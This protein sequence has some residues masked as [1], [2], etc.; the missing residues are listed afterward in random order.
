MTSGLFGHYSVT[1]VPERNQHPTWKNHQE[2]QF[3]FDSKI[4]LLWMIK[5]TKQVSQSIYDDYL[6]LER[7]FS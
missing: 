2:F 7:G 3:L 4:L 1:A 5:S 6:V